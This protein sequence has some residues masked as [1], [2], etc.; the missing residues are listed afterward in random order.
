MPTAEDRRFRRYWTGRVRSRGFQRQLRTMLAEDL[1]SMAGEK[2]GDVIDA[3]RVRKAIERRDG[4]EVADRIVADLAIEANRVVAR[5]LR[6][7]KRS[8]RGLLDDD[9]AAGVDALLEERLVLTRHAEELIAE[10]MRQ[11]LVRD[12]FTDVIHTSIVSFYKRIDPIFGGVTMRAVEGQIKSF[13]GLFM[14]LVQDRATAFVVDK[15]NQEIFADFARS[16]ARGLFDEP[17]PN[18]MSLVATGNASKTRAV[19]RALVRSPKLRALNREMTLAVWDKVF[20]RLRNEKVGD[21]LLIEDNADRWAAEAVDLLLPALVRPRVVD[22]IERE[23][24]L[25]ARH[26]GRI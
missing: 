2:V 12:I 3:K 1:R 5:K 13:I 21:V 19:V 23:L 16:I 26:A 25:A 6:A 20:A 17:L 15:R 10:L 14:P 7:K 9:L 4:T 11:E 18:L 8:V 22:F 24:A